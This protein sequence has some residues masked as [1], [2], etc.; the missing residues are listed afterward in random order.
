MF[1]ASSAINLDCQ[2]SF[3][4]LPVAT[5]IVYFPICYRRERASLGLSKFTNSTSETLMLPSLSKFI[6]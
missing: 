6:A 3:K 2:Q 4:S 5:A 1:Q